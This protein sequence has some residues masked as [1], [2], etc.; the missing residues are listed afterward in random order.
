[1]RRACSSTSWPAAATLERHRD[2]SKQG[3]FMM[4]EFMSLSYEVV[5]ALAAG[6]FA[7]AEEA[8]ERAHALGA[9]DTPFD[10]GVYGLQ[11]FAI[12]REQGRLVERLADIDGADGSGQSSGGHHGRA[13][14][15]AL[16]ADGRARLV[17]IDQKLAA[18]SDW[19]A[20]S[21]EAVV[22]EHAES[23]GAKLGQVAQPLR[24]ALTGRA[25]SPGLFD[26]M[27]VLGKDETLLR[28]QDQFKDAPAA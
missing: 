22:R 7:A 4:F 14:T 8:A 27:A 12:R 18:I 21:V 24:A 9:D 19:S 5:L 23:I 11:M 25:T 6:R 20:Q 10:S 3:R 15:L 1:M 26:V 13:S 17:G 28:L 2:L 16:L